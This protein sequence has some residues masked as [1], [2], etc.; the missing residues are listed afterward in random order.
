MDAYCTIYNLDESKPYCFVARAFDTEGFESEDSIE[1]CLEPLFITNQPPSADAGPDQ[2]VDEG[3]IVM[4]NGSNSTD[5]DDEIVSYHWV[6]IGGPG[7]NLSDPAAKQ[8]TF[9]APDVAFGGTALTFELTV[10][11]HNGYQGKDSCVVNVTW[12]N[13]PPRAIAGADQ[14]VDEG[15]MVTLDGSLSLDI[16]DGI[17]TYLWTQ[18]GFPTATLSDPATSMPT[19]IAPDVGPEGVSLTFH[20]TVTDAGNLQHTDACIVNITWQNEPPT[21]VVAPDYLETT[22]EALVILDGSASTD[23]DDGIA[24]YLWTQVEGDPISFSNPTS[25]VTSFTA[26]TTDAFEKNIELR[27]TVTDHGGLK[28]TVDSSIYVMQNEPPTLYSVTITGSSQVNESSGAQYILT[29]IYSDGNSSDVTGFASWRDNSSYASINSNG[30]L[31]ASSVT[32][33]QPCTITVSYEGQSDTHNVIIEN[34]PPNNSPVVD[35]T[36]ATS[37]KKVTFNDRSTDSD[38]TIVSWLWD[39]GDGTYNI[40]QNSEHRYTKFRN[41]SVTLTVTDNEGVSNSIS[42]TVSIT[43]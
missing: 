17:S 1:V 36:Y 38:G 20:L 27:L 10:T 40:T 6:Q 29:A 28:G 23:S 5:P 22:E 31:T 18:I 42:K 37:R 43:K 15:A 24:S 34:I 2:I 19:F 41:Y 8:L 11:D 12:Q 4:L 9:A 16:D 13:E 35:F 32:S 39:F 30:Y 21:A 33:D 26:P 3:Q 7:V 25:A 14:T